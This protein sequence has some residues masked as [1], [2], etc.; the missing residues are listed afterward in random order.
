MNRLIDVYAS[1]FRLHL[2]WALQYRVMIATWQLAGLVEVLVALS[3]WTA[4]ASA[5][6]GQVAG[7]AQADFAAYFVLVMLVG[8]LTHTWTVWIWEWRVRSG[9]FAGILVRPTHPLH[10]DI[11]DHVAAKLVSMS[12]KT[13]IALVVA[14]YF[15]ASFHASGWQWAA[16]V[17]ALALAWGLRIMIEACLACLAFWLTRI[18]AAVHAYYAVMLVMSGGFAPLAVL[19]D[20]VRVVAEVLPFRW[21]M[22]FPVE[23]GMGRLGTAEILQGL[24]FQTAWLLVACAAFHVCWRVTSR[25][26][27]AVGL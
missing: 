9:S 21:M 12:V 15:G 16:F 18:A 1:W 8:E 14:W 26:F 23:L 2:A 17:P 22:A 25:H 4:V 24:A 20:P 3:V 27:T 10:G 19:P 6:G 11:M 7:F 5:S 13:P